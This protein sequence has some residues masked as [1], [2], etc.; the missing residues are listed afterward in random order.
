VLRDGTPTALVIKPGVS[1][2]S[3]TEILEGELEPGDRCIT[4]AISLHP[5]ASA[6]RIL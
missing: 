3:T 1:D 4:E 2:G 6:P 5:G